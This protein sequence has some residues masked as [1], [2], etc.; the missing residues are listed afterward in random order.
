VYQYRLSIYAKHD[1]KFRSIRT[2]FIDSWYRSLVNTF[3]HIK[4]ELVRSRSQLPN[5]AVYAIETN[6]SLP[7]EETLLP[8]A[9]RSLVRY[10]SNSSQV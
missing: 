1:E 7:V 2:E 10:I 8:I 3:E 4:S 6:I 5:P 9:K